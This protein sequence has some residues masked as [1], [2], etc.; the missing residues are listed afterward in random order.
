MGNLKF[1]QIVQNNEADIVEEGDKTVDF[2][3][4]M[5]WAMFTWGWVV[6]TSLFDAELTTTV[7]TLVSYDAQTAILVHRHRFGVQ[8]HEMKQYQR[9]DAFP[10]SCQVRLMPC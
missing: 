5:R 7:E 4:S 3:R 8:H 6:E 9:D 2:F 1:D 10:V